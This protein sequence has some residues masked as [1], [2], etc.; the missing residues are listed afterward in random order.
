MAERSVLVA[1][2]T[3]NRC[4][5]KYSP[6]AARAAQKRKSRT[7]GSWRMDE[8]Y[9]K[10]RGEWVYLFRAVDSDG[11]ALDFVLSENRDTK[12]AK[13]FFANVLC[14]NGI[15]KTDHDRQ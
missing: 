11:Q 10:V 7:A 14:N 2:A 8:T 15:P 1:P 3:L 4:V 9:L 5:V 12:S 6:L 13:K